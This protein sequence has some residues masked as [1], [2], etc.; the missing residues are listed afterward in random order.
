ML[1]PL[2]NLTDRIND[3]LLFLVL[4]DADA[5][6]TRGLRIDRFRRR[7]RCHGRAVVGELTEGVE[8]DLDSLPRASPEDG[9]AGRGEE[10]R[11]RS[12]DVI[13][14]RFTQLLLLLVMG[15]LLGNGK[16]ADEMRY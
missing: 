4:G 2:T 6:G 10:W 9:R 8:R 3:R 7:C 13:G 1:H 11:G 14:P 16:R 15:R 12:G 5:V